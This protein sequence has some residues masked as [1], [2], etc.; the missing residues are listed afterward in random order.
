MNHGIPKQPT[1]PP[2]PPVH[3][4]TRLKRLKI[5]R[6]KLKDMK[7][8]SFG[9]KDKCM[10]WYD[11]EIECIEKWGADNPEYKEGV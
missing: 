9:L 6:E 2:M 5:E 8:L 1:I 10:E 4:M 11:H 7:L 3:K